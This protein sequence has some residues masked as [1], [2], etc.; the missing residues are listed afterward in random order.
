MV[1]AKLGRAL[2]KAGSR[3]NNADGGLFVLETCQPIRP[4]TH[5]SPPLAAYV[6]VEGALADKGPSLREKPAVG[7]AVTV[8]A[9]A[10][11]G[12]HSPQYLGNARKAGTPCALVRA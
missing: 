9:Y 3:R 2:G 5:V 10:G 8:V 11:T 12:A 4:G 7:M 6:A 1:I